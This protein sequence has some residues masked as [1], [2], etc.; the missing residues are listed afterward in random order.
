MLLTLNHP[1]YERSSYAVCRKTQSKLSE[2]E[3]LL[4]CVWEVLSLNL[5]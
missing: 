4:M 5:G 3:M 2:V 1:K